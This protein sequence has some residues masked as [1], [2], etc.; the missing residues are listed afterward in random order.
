MN[1]FF[2]IKNSL[3]SCNLTVPKFQNSGKISKECALYEAF[4]ENNLWSI[5]KS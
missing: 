4:P 1:F 2:G 5:N 3:L